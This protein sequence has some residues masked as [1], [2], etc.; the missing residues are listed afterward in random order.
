MKV[1][2]DDC[3][4][5]T[6]SNGGIAEYYMVHYHVWNSIRPAQFLCVGCLERRLGRRLVHE[7]FNWQA[8]INVISE[9]SERLL[10]RMDRCPLDQ[11]GWVEQR[12]T[13]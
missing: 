11:T 3:G 2:C 4:V 5:N 9:Y 8:P 1:P 7:D 10:L 12:A 13:A 6:S